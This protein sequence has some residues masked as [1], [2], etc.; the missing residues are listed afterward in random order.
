MITSGMKVASEVT[1]NSID[2]RFPLLNVRPAPIANSHVNSTEKQQEHTNHEIIAEQD[3]EKGTLT[4]QM[5]PKQWVII[6][7]YDSKLFHIYS[8]WHYFK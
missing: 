1:E 3:Q 2:I 8:Y 7:M 5:D 6:R 4:N